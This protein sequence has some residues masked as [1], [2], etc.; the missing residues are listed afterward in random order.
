M[1]GQNSVSPLPPL[2]TCLAHESSREQGL[3]KNP[4]PDFWDSETSHRGCLQARQFVWSVQFIDSNLLTHSQSLSENSATFQICIF[5]FLYSKTRYM[6]NLG[7]NIPNFGTI[8]KI[9]IV[10][11]FPQVFI[12]RLLDT[13]SL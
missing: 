7:K 9:V 5:N 8:E 10:V 6:Y 2:T 1:W 12:S 11:R 4:A 3:K 13:F